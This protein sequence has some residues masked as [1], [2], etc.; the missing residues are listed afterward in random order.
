MNEELV[1][2]LEGVKKTF[3]DFWLRAT[4]EAV[5]SLSLGVRR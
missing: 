4:V 2:E 5:S 3:R 1:I